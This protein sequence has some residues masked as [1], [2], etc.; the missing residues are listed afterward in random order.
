MCRLHR[1]AKAIC[2]RAGHQCHHCHV[3]TKCGTARG[4]GRWCK[5]LA[6]RGRR[7]TPPNATPNAPTAPLRG[8]WWQTCTRRP[9]R[10]GQ[11]MQPPRPKYDSPP[12]FRKKRWAEFTAQSLPSLSSS[13]EA[14]AAVAVP[15]LYSPRRSRGDCRHC[16]RGNR[17][18]R[19][20]PPPL[21]LP[22]LLLSS[23][24]PPRPCRC[25]PP[26]AQNPTTPLLSS[27]SLS[28]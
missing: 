20:R 9:Q 19:W 11:D 18:R 5:W 7:G 22:S 16:H 21:S 10:T 24:P 3:D 23:P 2:R 13:L 1:N 4:E 27:S 14:T 17:N 6:A 15:R 8:G 25:P 28:S 26:R 12:S